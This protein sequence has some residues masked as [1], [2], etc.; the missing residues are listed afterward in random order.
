M[1][2]DMP[3]FIVGTYVNSFPRSAWECRPGRS[4]ASSTGPP[5]QPEMP[6]RGVGDGIPTRSVGTSGGRGTR[7]Y[8]LLV[9]AL[10]LPVPAR[11]G[12]VRLDV[13]RDLWLSSVGREAD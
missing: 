3:I 2:H 5:A 4:A 13:T 8:L 6:T 9:M 7:G 11:A 12:E 10:A 1:N